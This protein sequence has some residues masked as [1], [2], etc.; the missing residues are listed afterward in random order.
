VIR[1]PA[2]LA[3]V[4][5]GALALSVAAIATGLLEPAEHAAVD[6]RFDVRGAQ[7]APQDV[8]VV[9]I[10]DKTFS[11]TQRHY[12]FPRR[13]DAQVVRRLTDAGVRGIVYDVQF[14]EQTDAVDDNALITAFAAAPNPVLATTE[15]DRDGHTAVLGGDANLR[16]L[17]ARAG[18]AAVPTD[19]AAGAVRRMYGRYDGLDTLAVAAV[20]AVTGKPVRWPG[21]TQWIDYAGPPGTVPTYS[22]VDVLQGRVPA[23]KLRGRV[24]VVGATSPSLG[25]VHATSTTGDNQV[26]SGPEI[27]A[28]AIATLLAGFPVRNAPAVV[29]VLLLLLGALVLPAAALR[30]RRIWA[31]LALA[32]GLAVLLALGAYAAFSGGWMVPVAGPG[33]ALLLSTIGTIAAVGFFAA[34]ERER[35]R[36]VFA[37]FVDGPVVDQLL[38]RDWV[39]RLGGV[40]VEATVLFA[41]LRG[42]TALLESLEPTAGLA[43][44]NRFLSAM[45]DAV[46]AHGGTLIGYRGDGLAALFGAPVAQADH[47]DRALAAA[48]DMTGPRLAA[49]NADLVTDGL[50]PLA[51]GVGMDSGRV[52]AGNVGSELRMEYTAIGDPANVAARVEGLTKELGRSVLLTAATRAALRGGD[53][54]LEPGRAHPPRGRPTGGERGAPAAPQLLDS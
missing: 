36:A 49:V 13:I 35:T 4:G 7:A 52:L 8:A 54:A 25:D 30:I 42:S 12:P 43:V 10:D 46:L 37:R 48:L 9:A 38:S 1:R 51:M 23:D 45:A 40:E 47:A 50:A 39:A 3:L 31:L 15:V 24:V 26:M 29:S 20:E 19:G 6:A 22:F 18:H 53:Q 27:Q 17:G 34:L 33:L 16:K 5:A 41:D 28:N 44:L 32:V 14:T 21:G 2:A 11:K